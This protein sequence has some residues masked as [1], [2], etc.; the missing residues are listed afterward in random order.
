MKDIRICIKIVTIIFILL[1]AIYVSPG[2]LEDDNDLSPEEPY[3]ELIY[4]VEISG[5]G[6]N[7]VLIPIPIDSPGQS[8]LNTNNVSKL[9][10][11]IEILSGSGEYKTVETKYGQALEINFSDTIH[12]KAKMKWEDQPSDYEKYFF[13]ELTMKNNTNQSSYNIY[14]EHGNVNIV[15]FKSYWKRVGEDV[16]S[17]FYFEL[18]N[19]QLEK[20][21]Q[22]LSKE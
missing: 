1:S 18:K 3:T 9:L 12:I 14:S 19:Y 11:H 20:G 6:D 15:L 22:L 10:D 8:D 16:D 2:C 5:E 21:W 13:D 4:E 17:P 7:S